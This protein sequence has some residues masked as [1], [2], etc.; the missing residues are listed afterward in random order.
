MEKRNKKRN[1]NNQQEDSDTVDVNYN[2]LKE[3]LNNYLKINEEV[4]KIKEKESEQIKKL[5]NQA[6]EKLK[7]LK[8]LKEENKLEEIYNIAALTVKSQSSLEITATNNKIKIDHLTKE[9]NILN[10]N[11]N[12]LSNKMSS[13]EK[14][15][16]MLLEKCNQLNEEKKKLV[17]EETEKRNE[18]I[19]KCEN[20]M[21]QMQSKF[22]MEIPEKEQLIHENEELRKQLEKT[23]VLLEEKLD[24]AQKSKDFFEENI[25][26]GMESKLKE[27]MTKE[28]VYASENTQLKAQLNIYSSKFD[29][30]TKSVVNYNSHYDTLKKEVDK[31]SRNNIIIK[32]LI[33]IIWYREILKM[34]C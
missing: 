27:L 29:E 12:S 1:K 23:K 33:Y 4:S 7:E 34:L 16:K 19:V 8:E 21:K 14:Y 11:I 10:E 20:F 6:I 13:T 26:T 9:N 31:V 5:K 24:F 15:S 32:Y 22:E 17:L 18:L 28:N 2:K 25:K 30:L 3:E